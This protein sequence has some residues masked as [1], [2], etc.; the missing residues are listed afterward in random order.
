LGSG[1]LLLAAS[2]VVWRWSV[3][4]AWQFSRAFL[5]NQAHF[6]ALGVVSLALVSKRR[7]AL[8]TYGG[9]LAIVLVICASQGSFGKMLPPLVWTLC[10]AAQM[11]PDT[12]GLRPVA[13]LLRS[14]AA[15]YLGAV[16]YCVYLVNEPL[17]KLI[18]SGL[19]RFAD[20]DGALFT[21]L[22]VP[23]A[24]LLPILVAIWLHVYVEQPALRRGRLVA[25]A[26][27]PPLVGLTGE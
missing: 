17:H 3:P 23:S 19:S 7:G 12:P 24:L 1:L 14:R 5:G 10:L 20:G 6:F 26:W 27:S 8:A 9:T 13:A 11:R 22:W 4:E 2:G 18:A 16:S 25:L 15:Q 21:V